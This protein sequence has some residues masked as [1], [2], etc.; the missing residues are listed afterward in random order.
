MAKTKGA[1]AVKA[2]RPSARSD[3]TSV[4]MKKVKNGYV[5]STYNDKTY[6]D[7]E[8]IAKNKKDAQKIAGRMLK[9]G[10]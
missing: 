4:T 8:Y 9:G 7:T 1:K 3:R 2:A 6:K 10:K 5:V